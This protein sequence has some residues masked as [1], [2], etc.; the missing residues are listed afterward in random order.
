V[1]RK[2][3][4][5]RA[6][7]AERR[8]TRPSAEAIESAR[9]SIAA[10]LRRSWGH[11]AEDIASEA[12]ARALGSFDAARGT[13]FDAYA[14]SIARNITN[15]RARQAR[16]DRG[17][18]V[19]RAKAPDEW[20]ALLQKMEPA[21]FGAWYR[22]TVRT[23]DA[24]AKSVFASLEYAIDNTLFL[25]RDLVEKPNFDLTEIRQAMLA[26]VIEELQSAHPNSPS[27]T[28]EDI[29]RGVLRTLG[30]QGQG[31]DR[32]LKGIATQNARRENQDERA[33]VRLEQSHVMWAFLCDCIEVD[34]NAK[35]TAEGLRAA[36]ELY[37]H[38]RGASPM[39]PGD[40]G[41]L[42]ADLDGVTRV[43]TKRGQEYRGIGLRNL[44][45][46]PV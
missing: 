40:F 8:T 27:I 24:R 21:E 35:V 46:R 12:I 26:A 30:I 31:F 6:A 44:T 39:A 4:P 2:R 18:P 5:R 25:I 34:V 10:G 33:R 16:R 20:A 17:E 15:E 11:D 41:H 28:A 42:V 37:C 7:P 45:E 38:E 23:I 13:F 1:R 9:Q 36:Y 19:E 29:M 14:W 22:R 3:A 43:R 32:W